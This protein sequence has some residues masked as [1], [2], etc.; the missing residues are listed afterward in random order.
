MLL[1]GMNYLAGVARCRIRLHIQRSSIHREGPI[2]ASQVAE[3]DGSDIVSNGCLIQD[4][5]THQAVLLAVIPP[6]HET[7][8]SSLGI[9]KQVGDR[10]GSVSA[11]WSGLNG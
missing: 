8:P 1:S 11:W 2:V 6:G 3:E 5:V 9:G 10:R 7:V 4:L